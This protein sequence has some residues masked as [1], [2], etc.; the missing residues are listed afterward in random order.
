MRFFT[1]LAQSTLA[2]R[3]ATI[4]LLAALA[5]LITQAVLTVAYG[6]PAPAISGVSMT[7]AAKPTPS[8]LAGGNAAAMAAPSDLKL[9]GV[10]AQGASGIALLQVTGKRAVPLHVGQALADGTVL[11]SVQGKTATVLINGELRTLTLDQAGST[12]AAAVN[13]TPSP[14]PN[15]PPPV[16]AMPAMAVTD[17]AQTAMQLQQVQQLQQLQQAAANEGQGAVAG[18][19]QNSALGAIKR[20]LGGRP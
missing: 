8:W 9:L 2:A 7:D 20:R 15:L 11:K 12:A 13:A 14:T 17:A 19:E 16:A 10:V 3:L 5:G 6:T 4:V 18:S 1:Q